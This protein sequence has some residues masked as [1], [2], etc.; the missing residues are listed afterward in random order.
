[1]VETSAAHLRMERRKTSQGLC[2][3]SVHQGIGRCE[4]HDCRL[5]VEPGEP[6][7]QGTYALP[8]LLRVGGDLLSGSGQ[9]E[10]VVGSLEQLGGEARFQRRHA[11]HDGH[12]RD[13]QKPACSRIGTRFSQRQNEPQVVPIKA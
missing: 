5:V 10:A 7:F 3:K 6:S 1:M 12:V 11:A 8:D 13:L 4:T 2:D 9:G